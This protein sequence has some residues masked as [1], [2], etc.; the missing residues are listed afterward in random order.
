MGAGENGGEEGGGGERRREAEKVGGWEG[1]RGEMLCYD[2]HLIDH[3][4]IN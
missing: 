4:L 2:A 1:G 3:F